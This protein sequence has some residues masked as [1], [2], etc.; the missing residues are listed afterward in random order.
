MELLYGSATQELSN[1]ELT[2]LESKLSAELVDLAIEK[3]RRADLVYAN[4]ARGTIRRTGPGL[5]AFAKGVFLSLSLGKDYIIRSSM[6]SIVHIVVSGKIK[7]ETGGTAFYCADVGGRLVTAAHLV[8]DRKIL[9]IENDRG[10]LQHCSPI[11]IQKVIEGLDLAVL[12][13]VAPDGVSCLRVEWD[14]EEISQLSTTYVVGFPQVPQQST[15]AMICRSA[16]LA[17]ISQDY[18]RRTTYLIT[19]VTSE[20]FS[21]GPAINERGRVIGVVKGVPLNPASTDIGDEAKLQGDPSPADQID[22]QEYD[23]RYSVLTPAWYLE[24][25]A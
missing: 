16:E 11:K 4:Y 7:P 23:A 25:L 17:G 13:V 20:G 2:W 12:D 21:G 5:N 24:E 22:A 14:K 6:P 18:T 19:N 8:V 1:H 10:A 9:K 3:L 15:S